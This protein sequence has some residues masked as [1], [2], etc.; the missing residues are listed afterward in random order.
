MSTGPTRAL[1]ELTAELDMAEK[2]AWDSLA[3]YKFW[4]FGLHAAIWVHLNRIGHFRR[5]N[6]WRILVEA[7]RER[8]PWPP[9]PEG[10]P[11]LDAATAEAATAEE[12]EVPAFL[13]RLAEV[14]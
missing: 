11:L 12:L 10:T 7:A 8:Q 2:K 9:A 14:A 13:Q 6:P 1:E 3:R 5:P 4:T